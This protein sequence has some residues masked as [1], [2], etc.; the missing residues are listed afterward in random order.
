MSKALNVFGLIFNLAG[1]VLLFLFG[2]PFRIASGGKTVT[3][4]T[5][6]IDLQVR[7]LDD[8]YSVLGWIG[9]LAIVFGTLLQIWATFE[10][11]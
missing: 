8:I 3:W 9:L 1:V 4:T 10:R 11:R 6:N 2:M 5:T 7:K